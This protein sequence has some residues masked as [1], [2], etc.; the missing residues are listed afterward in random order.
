MQTLSAPDRDI[1]FTVV[2]GLEAVRQG[3]LQRLRFWRGEWFLDATEGVPYLTDLLGDRLDTGLV[4]SV[5]RDQVL[6][7]PDVTGVSNLT[8]TEGD[9]SFIV[10]MD[11]QTTFGST[12]LEGGI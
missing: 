8:V 6:A 9:R 4:Q 2:S 5:V 3:I 10:G 7:V 1:D 12:R 11:V